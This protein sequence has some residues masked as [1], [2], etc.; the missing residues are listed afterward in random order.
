[1]RNF[2]ALLAGVSSVAIV[3]A[4]GVPALA[5]SDEYVS[6]LNGE[7][8]K[9]R[10]DQRSDQ[11]LLPALA[12]VKPEEVPAI[13]AAGSQAEL[14][15]AGSAAWAS[16]EAWAKGEPQQAA[17]KALREATKP[18]E[19]GKPGMAFGLPYGTSVEPK[20]LIA[21]RLY[22][23]LDDPPTLAG[24]QY[25]YMPR[26]DILVKL[27]HVEAT[28]LAAEGKPIEAIRLLGNLLTLGRQMAD[29]EMFV[30][31]RWGYQVMLGALERIRDVAY[32]DMRSGTP[33]LTKDELQSIIEHL[34]DTKG[35]LRFD[36]LQFPDGNHVAAQ[37]VA[38]RV[39]TAGAGADPAKMGATLAKLASNDRPLRLFNETA[40]LAAAS[41]SHANTRDTKAKVDGIQG[42]WASRWVLKWF[43]KRMQDPSEYSKLD[44]TKYALVDSVYPDMGELFH[45]RQLLQ[46]EAVGTRYSIA[47]VGYYLT[48]RTFAPVVT[49]VVP[50]WLAKKEGDP[51]NPTGMNNREVPPLSYFVPIRDTKERASDSAGNVLPHQMAVIAGDGENFTV[52]LKDDTFVLYSWGS[53]NAKNWAD[54]VQNTWRVVQGA[55]YLLWPPMVSLHRQYLV[56]TG[57]MK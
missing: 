45:M 52:K 18:G 38:S 46:V 3:S 57:K 33:K 14:I 20:S 25:L 51:Y 19:P 43:D 12:K 49:S 11:I 36:R 50:A 35:S 40:K 16:L 56:D 21:A 6:K 54:R 32:V 29:R 24:A 53:D 31:V 10:A 47:L 55:D 30:E 26:M 2:I 39:M 4:W 9:I 37:Q 17:L 27:T 41:E 1:M 42:D 8:A 48:N 28:R 5:Q 15:P 13:L 22:V 23:E 44:R 34:D 7:Y